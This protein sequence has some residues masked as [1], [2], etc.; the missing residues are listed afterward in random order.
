MLDAVLAP[1]SFLVDGLRD[2]DLLFLLLG[3]LVVV[4][5][6]VLLEGIY[7]RVSIA[8]ANLPQCAGGSHYP[9]FRPEARK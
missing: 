2:V 6:N 7:L 9:S 4:A 3:Q 8:T 5:A 1:W